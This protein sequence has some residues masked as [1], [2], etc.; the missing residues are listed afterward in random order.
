MDEKNIKVKI[1]NS[2]LTS[3]SFNQNKYIGDLYECEKQIYILEKRRKSLMLKIG[4]ALRPREFKQS[5]FYKEYCMQLKKYKDYPKQVK[6]PGNLFSNL[7]EILFYPLYVLFPS[8]IVNVI[9][10]FLLWDIVI[11]PGIIVIAIAA[12]IGFLVDLKKYTDDIKH[13]N[14]YL[15]NY[16]KVKKYNSDCEKHNN[17]RYNY[18]LEEFKK[19]E[20]SRK[21]KFFS[22]EPYINAEINAIDKQLNTV[23]NT[24][25][26]LYNLKINGVL[27]LHPNYRG[28][29]PISIIY[30]YFDTGRCSQL[31]GHE[32]A[33]NLYEDEKMKGIII[34]KL[35]V[36]S[37]QIGDLNNS[38][39]YVGQAIQECNNRLSALEDAG[40]KM[41]GTMHNINKN[42]TNK[43]SGVSNQL[44]YIEE[45]TA[46]SAYYSEISAKMATFNTVYNFLKD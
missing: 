14:I 10:D 24:L 40:D 33:Y 45:N 23:Q 16:N 39:I 27:C 12:I 11:W 25:N 44:S 38:M 18:W 30:G 42:V 43:L 29:L 22:E 17:E 6:N 31:Q 35:D 2:P 32:G 4:S 5:K 7:T 9:F 36:V 3:Q 37:K 28:L 41:I 15:S 26:N 20:K 46:N 19:S 8:L 34:N 13:Y 21:D 1:S